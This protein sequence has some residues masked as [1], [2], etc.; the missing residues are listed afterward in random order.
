MKATLLDR[1][2][3]FNSASTG[4]DDVGRV[5]SIEGD[6]KYVYRNVSKKHREFY[7]DLVK[8]LDN[9]AILKKYIISTEISDYTNEQNEMILR[10]ERI[11]AVNYPWEWSRGMLRD[12]ALMFIN[13][14][15]ELAKNGYFTKDAHSFNVILKDNV[16]CFVDLGSI[17]KNNEI[18]SEGWISEFANFFIYPLLYI[19]CFG[20]VKYREVMIDQPQKGF[21]ID[22]LKERSLR[23]LNIQL[24]SSL[25]GYFWLYNIAKFVK[26]K[27]AQITYLENLRYYVEGINLQY[28]K[29][30]WSNYYDDHDISVTYKTKWNDKQ[31]S[32]CDVAES[33]EVKSV[34]DLAGNTG[35]YLDLFAYHNKKVSNLFLFDY[36]EVCIDNIYKQFKYT[37]LVVDFSNI[38]N[39][40]NESF[41]GYKFT[42]ESIDKRIKGDLVMALALIHHLV[43]KQKCSFDK[44][45]EKLSLLTNK[46]CLVEFI[47][48]EDKY[49]SEWYNEDFSWYNLKNFQAALTKNFV[50]RKVYDS[51][52]KFRTIL[53]CEKK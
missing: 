6:E 11:N 5:F 39:D 46:Y 45:V 17:I 34:V 14:N 52:L 21:T 24:I 47:S 29:T 4:I 15:I 2:I 3:I 23:I 20:G 43:F 9:N 30:E 28:T 19:S 10:H 40:V 49:V 8:I 18:I 48:K 1:D 42:L 50:I 44:I 27:N 16:P 36:D 38:G 26:S 33:V 12:A 51:N 41:M 53:L 22:Q 31:K 32:V 25:L 37:C 35:F 13:I 7:I